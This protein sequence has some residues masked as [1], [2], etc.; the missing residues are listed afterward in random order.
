MRIVAKQESVEKASR[1]LDKGVELGGEVT[2]GEALREE[3]I[4]ERYEE[5]GL[6]E[7]ERNPFVDDA[8][9]F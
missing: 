7:E 1:E 2:G 9:G 5:P 4:E 3:A 8:I 6:D